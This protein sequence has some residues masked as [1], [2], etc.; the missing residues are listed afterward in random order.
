MLL[1]THTVILVNFIELEIMWFYFK[2]ILWLLLKNAWINCI[3][4]GIIM[5][6]ILSIVNR[7]SLVCIGMRREREEG[8][9]TLYNYKFLVID[10]YP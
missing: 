6:F 2:Y 10:S 5:Q 3:W 8:E 1:H 4:S 9:E 7:I